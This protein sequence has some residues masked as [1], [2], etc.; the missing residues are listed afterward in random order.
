MTAVTLLHR[1]RRG[2]GQCVD[3]GHISASYRCDGCR[4]IHRARN[5]KRSRSMG[6][7]AWQPGGRGRPPLD[8]EA[9]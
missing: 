2:V 5:N 4:A 6:F 1:K 8:G 7:A 3:C 9:I